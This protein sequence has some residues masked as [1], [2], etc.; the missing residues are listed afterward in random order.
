MYAAWLILYFYSYMY[1]L[2]FQVTFYLDLKVK[3][4]SVSLS[5]SFRGAGMLIFL[6]LDKA[7]PAD[8]YLSRSIDDCLK[9]LI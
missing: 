8:L 1:Y 3:V 9:L 4:I 2:F 6:L 7:S 5:V